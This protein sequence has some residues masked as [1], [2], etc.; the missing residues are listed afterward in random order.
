MHLYYISKMVDFPSFSL[1]INPQ[2]AFYHGRSSLVEKKHL[3]VLSLCAFL[4]TFVFS[5]VI[6]AL[7]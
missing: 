7:C 6:V 2:E 3:F 1:E 4:K 5:Y